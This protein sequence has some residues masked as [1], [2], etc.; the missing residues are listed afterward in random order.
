[1]A[2]APTV[3]ALALPIGAHAADQ[4]FG[5]VVD[6]ISPKINGLTI[7]GSAGGCDLIVQNQ[8]G[9]NVVLLS[10]IHI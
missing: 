8:T 1:M 9:Q 6:G 7:Q 4:P 2:L 3:L 5:T 10:L